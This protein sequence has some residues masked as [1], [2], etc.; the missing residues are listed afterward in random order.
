MTLGGYLPT[1][2]PEDS[3][4]PSISA[5]SSLAA[6]CEEISVIEKTLQ[7]TM[8]TFHQAADTL[9][10]DVRPDL[11]SL[12]VVLTPF[13]DF[14]RG[15]F[16]KYTDAY[17]SL[18]LSQLLKH[19]ILLDIVPLYLLDSNESEMVSQSGPSFLPWHV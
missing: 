9:M 8:L 7:A 3:C 19:Y 12:P 11:S 5:P 14:R 6:D 1:H 17:I 18:S 2:Q 13:A 4:V 15:H 16:K 10:Q